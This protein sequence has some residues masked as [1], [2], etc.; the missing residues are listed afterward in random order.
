MDAPEG[1]SWSIMSSG[2]ESGDG[3]LVR[4]PANA[5]VRVTVEGL[6]RP[7]VLLRDPFDR[8][9][10]HD[11]AD[12]RAQVEAVGLPRGEWLIEVRELDPPGHTQFYQI[13]VSYEIHDA[14]GRVQVDGTQA[15]AFHA[16]RPAGGF[17]RIDVLHDPLLSGRGD[18]VFLFAERTI[19]SGIDTTVTE[20]G[21][22]STGFT[23][24][25]AV[26]PFPLEVPTSFFQVAWGSYLG[27]VGG[28]DGFEYWLGSAAPSSLSVSAYAVWDGDAPSMEKLEG[29]A[30]F[31]RLGDLESERFL[32][33][34]KRQSLASEATGRYDADGL[35]NLVYVDARARNDIF[36]PLMTL[37]PPSGPAIPVGDETKLIALGDAAAGEWRLDVD[38]YQGTRE[39]DYVLVGV[40]MPF[41]ASGR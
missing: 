17:A 2:F 26:R 36:S 7:S 9:R 41:A 13:T 29:R 38:R 11:E 4:P 39:N 28:S 37:T 19:A 33:D 1:T 14:S 16:S 34:A 6:E 35:S 5:L 40:S 15:M 32:V 30:V 18:G 8:F 27:R 24:Q 23:N 21:A 31:L 22:G 12:D 3:Y 10:D 20:F 25:V